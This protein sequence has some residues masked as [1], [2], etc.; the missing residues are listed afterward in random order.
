[1]P[2]AIELYL[3]DSAD[4]QVRQI[5]AALDE[6]GVPSPGSIPDA[7]YHPHISVSVFDHGDTMRVAETVRPLLAEVMGLPLRL[8]SLGFFLTSTAPAFLGVVPSMRLLHLHHDLHAAIQPMVSEIWQHYRPSALVP[9][10][11]LAMHVANKATVIDVVSR[12]DIPIS[13]HAAS[14][15]LVQV[16]GG[17]SRAPLASL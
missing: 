9:H 6:R 17:R 14:A 1:M 7:D 11:T 16:P 3:D 15:H 10:C 5:W 4:R 12:F 8:E 13:A 2:L